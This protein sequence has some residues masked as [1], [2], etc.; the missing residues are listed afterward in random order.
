MIGC[1]N[2]VFQVRLRL[3][4]IIQANLMLLRSP[5]TIFVVDM[6]TKRILP[7]ADFGRIV[8]R[9]HLRARNITLRP[10]VDGLYVTVPPFTRLDTVVRTVESYRSR[11]KDSFARIGPR[12]LTAQ[13]VIDADCF[14]LKVEVGPVRHFMVSCR[15]D[16]YVVVCPTDTDFDSDDAQRLLR[17][18]IVRALKHRASRYLP[19]LLDEWSVRMGLSYRKVRITGAKTKWGS[20]TSAKTISLSCYLMLLP[21][22]LMDYVIL[23]E[24]AHT[25]E[26]NHGDAFYALL[27]QLTG[28]VAVSLRKELKKFRTEF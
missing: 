8:V 5:C 24:L 4:K 3:G 15:A 23:H 17:A 21:P 6:A 25:R 27:N 1:G 22:H 19:V 10:K 7:D 14:K 12:R 16:R 28:G 18:A 26:M 2:V 20:C 11:L 13:T 9:S